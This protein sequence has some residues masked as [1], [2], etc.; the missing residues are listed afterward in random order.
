M[1]NVDRMFIL[2]GIVFLL[3]GLAFGLNMAMT[4]DFTL[5]DLHAHLNLLGFVLM[6][7]FGLCYHN[8]PKM[9]EG[10][11]AT[12]H[13]LIHTITVAIALFMLYFLLKDT[14]TYG[15]VLGPWIGRTLMITYAGLLLFGYLFLTRARD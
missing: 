5:R 9:Q 6:T 10:M 14:P 3:V 4:D 8:W 7:L 12:I 1:K 2:T 11:L 15:P 13:Y